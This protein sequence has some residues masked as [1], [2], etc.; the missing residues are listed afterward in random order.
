MSMTF[1]QA[2]GSI[3][4]MPPSPSL[5]TG[6]GLL[7]TASPF[8]A[9]KAI[10]VVGRSRSLLAPQTAPPADFTFAGAVHPTDPQQAIINCVLP[11]GDYDITATVTTTTRTVALFLPAEA[12]DEL[13]QTHPALAGAALA[14]ALEREKQNAQALGATATPADEYLV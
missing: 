7:S 9:T 13:A 4:Q 10:T 5:S 11:D 1:G 8:D 2:L 3:E 6:L 12:F 14:V